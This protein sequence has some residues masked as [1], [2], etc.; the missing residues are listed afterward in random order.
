MRSARIFLSCFLRSFLVGAGM[1]S[2][3]MQN[4]GLLFALWPGLTAIHTGPESRSLAY[5]RYAGHY[6]CHP[7]WTPMLIGMFLRLEDLHS[8]G[9]LSAEMLDRFRNTTIHT[10]SA[11]GDSFFEGSL[12]VL[13]ALSSALLVIT[14]N[15]AWALIWSGLFI[16][17]LIAFKFYSFI[18]GWRSGLTALNNVKRWNLINR[19]DFIKHINALL[20]AALFSLLLA[21]GAFGLPG[22]LFSP[23]ALNVKL[24]L[25]FSGCAIAFWALVFLT[26]RLHAPRILAPL[27]SL[28]ALAL[29]LFFRYYAPA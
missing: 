16:A 22:G 26:A 29:A 8:K 7:I 23:V 2:R 5:R 11:I 28:L 9:L 4:I 14:G 10:L 19:G 3:G 6:N 20:A 21:Q 12:V 18:L 13:W 27:I 24:L 15:A 1:N 25:I 17:G